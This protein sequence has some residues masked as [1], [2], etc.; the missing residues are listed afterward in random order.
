MKETRM[1]GRKDR[2]KMKERRNICTNSRKSSVKSRSENEGFSG[3][4]KE[5]W[6]RR[7]IK[8]YSRRDR[9]TNYN[10]H[11]IAAVLA[12]AKTKTIIIMIIRI[13]TD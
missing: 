9:S 2:R 8:W 7:K 5:R 12:L 1:D 3:Q 10:C 13:T 4:R 6:P 11:Q